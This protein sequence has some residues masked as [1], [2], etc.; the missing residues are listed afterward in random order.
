MTT[1]TTTDDDDDDDDAAD[2]DGDDYYLKASLLRLGTWVLLNN[3]ARTN[4]RYVNWQGIYIT[5][6]KDERKEIRK[7]G[8]EGKE[9][10]FNGQRAR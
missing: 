2:D 7:E 4:S 3:C 1:T 6:G 9:G 5:D 10:F 8:R